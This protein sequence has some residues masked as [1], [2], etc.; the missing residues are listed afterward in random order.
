MRASA[1]PSQHKLLRF[2]GGE[3]SRSLLSAYGSV[4]QHDD[5]MSED[6]NQ[7][8]LWTQEY[9]ALTLLGGGYGIR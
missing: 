9:V 8:I 6:G 3:F 1:E 7:V 2:V 5:L 4:S